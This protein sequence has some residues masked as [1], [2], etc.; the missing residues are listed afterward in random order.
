MDKHF[1]LFIFRLAS[2]NKSEAALA[3]ALVSR[4]T[5]EGN[6][7][8]ALDEYAGKPLLTG[9]NAPARHSF[10]APSLP[11]WTKQLRQSG[12]VGTEKSYTPLVLDSK[13][14]LYL[15]RYWEYENTINRFI[16]QR[17]TQNH[18]ELDHERLAA[19]LKTLFPKPA[20][21]SIDWQMIAAIAAARRSFCVISGGPGTGKT[22]TVAKILAL[23]R[24]Q[25][26]SDS[27]PR[28][29]LGA[30]TGKAASRLQQAIAD[31][32]LLQTGTTEPLQATTLHRMLGSIP[33][34]PYFRHNAE[35][36]LAADIVVVDEASMVDLPLMAKLM[37]AV[38]DTARLI[39]LGDHHQLASVQPGSFFGDICRPEIMAGFSA[40]FCEIANELT[41]CRLAPSSAAVSNTVSPAMQD[42]FIELLQ[43]YRFDPDSSIARLSLAVKEGDGEGAFEILSASKD[44]TISWSDIPGPTE[45]GKKL[46]QWPDFEHF[47]TLQQTSEPDRCFA[48]L[49]NLRILCALRNGPFGM[50]KINTLVERQLGLQ[51]PQPGAYSVPPSRP[52]M[53][54]QNDYA[55]QLFNGDIGILQLDP[56]NPATSQAFFKNPEGR[57]RTLSLP[58]LPTHETV[59]AMTV[60][61]SQGTEFDRVLLILPDRDSPLL[62][63]ELI[64]TA[65]TRARKG[66]EIWGSRDIFIAAVKRKIQ[67]TS[68]LPELLWSRDS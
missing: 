15:R 38:P 53:V 5:R 10:S 59:F 17:C 40:E 66:V 14:R 60:H 25:H 63:R 56:E 41:S 1:A 7:C 52:I 28:I 35:N 48:L 43:S 46:L 68:G 29:L 16:R 57:L 39:L 26:Q 12:V 21:G 24:G 37:Q 64:Y 19:D 8:M 33:N 45:L 62:T 47:K 27:P 42:S 30:P 61:K 55:L 9:N 65:I 49:E 36:P 58:L 31:T 54:T 51:V 3:A 50:E 6:I 13:G 22:F 44:D 2:S 18:V 23:I 11:E 34:S 20:D 32:G 67:R 4:K